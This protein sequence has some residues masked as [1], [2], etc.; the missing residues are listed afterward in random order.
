MDDVG[1]QIGIATDGQRVQEA[2]LHNRAAVGHTGLL[3]EGSCFCG[4]ARKINQATAQVRMLAQQGRQGTPHPPAHVNDVPDGRPVVRTSDGGPKHC[5]M[6]VHLRVV[7]LAK[8]GLGGHIVPKRQPVQVFPGRAA[9]AHRLQQAV[10]ALV[11][12]AEKRVGL[13]QGRADADGVAVPQGFAHLR[14]LEAA[15]RRGAEQS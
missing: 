11:Q 14:H 13:V 9:S 15:I 5:R 1:D 7:A 8:T 3:E 10:G 2:L 12:P 6:L 4:G